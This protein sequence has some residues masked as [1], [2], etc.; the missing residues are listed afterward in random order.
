MG[1]CKVV[2]VLQLAE[3]ERMAKDNDANAVRELAKYYKEVGNHG[4][5]RA[6][7]DKGVELAEPYCQYMDVVY[8]AG[9]FVPPIISGK[10]L[11]VLLS[12]AERGLEDAAE[13]FC[14]YVAENRLYDRGAK[15]RALAES[16][17]TKEPKRRGVLLSLGLMKFEE[18]FGCLDLTE[19]Y[20]HLVEAAL[21]GSPQAAMKVLPIM[22]NSVIEDQTK[23][24]EQVLDVIKEDCPDYA[25]FMEIMFRQWLGHFL[26]FS[27]D[28]ALKAEQGGRY[29]ALLGAYCNL[30]G[31][32]QEPDLVKARHY[33]DLAPEL[34]KMLRVWL[35][36]I[37]DGVTDTPHA[38]VNRMQFVIEE[39]VKYAASTAAA[40]L[41][42]DSDNGEFSAE[43][44]LELI[45]MAKEQ[46]D[47]NAWGLMAYIHHYGL[48]GYEKDDAK[49][50]EEALCAIRWGHCP[51]A[52]HIAIAAGDD[53][54]R[55][56]VE[57]RC[58]RNFCTRKVDG[59]YPL[60]EELAMLYDLWYRRNNLEE[61]LAKEPPY[62]K[63]LLLESCFRNLV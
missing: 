3:W 27:D 61:F 49:A 48:L 54:L 9:E 63:R 29:H 38:I 15:A 18:G 31:I 34:T 62:G 45:A 52:Y 33:I 12:C 24:A 20:E 13:L 43:R 10:D 57:F 39:K 1:T 2:P 51:I 58:F 26:S 47:P 21:L 16:F 55:G 35:G 5:E 23:V 37:E 7:I 36:C 60:S 6:Y 40:L 28:L 44:I 59:V 25:D 30:F 50:A 4:L 42:G 14:A 56:M 19:G 41:L 17:L 53:S 11:D 22:Y 8:K 46:R 32:G